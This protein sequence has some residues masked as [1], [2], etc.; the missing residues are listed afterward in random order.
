VAAATFF[1]I[2]KGKGSLWVLQTSWRGAQSQLSWV[3]QVSSKYTELLYRTPTG[4]VSQYGRQEEYLLVL[5][6]CGSFAT[7]LRSA[8]DW[9]AG[10]QRWRSHDWLRKQADGGGRLHVNRS[11]SKLTTQARVQCSAVT[12][13]AKSHS[14]VS[15]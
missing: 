8:G 4:K 12:V 6:V 14:N 13:M 11:G 5:N 9:E 15:R 1:G 3:R 2:P 7:Q 10:L